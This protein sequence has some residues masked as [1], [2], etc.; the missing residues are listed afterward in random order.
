MIA[1][2]PTSKLGRFSVVGR[3][4]YVTACFILGTLSDHATDHPH[5][6]IPLAE[7]MKA[8]SRPQNL[9]DPFDIP[10][11]PVSESVSSSDEELFEHALTLQTP[12]APTKPV[13][14][15]PP[16]PPPRSKITTDS[17]TPS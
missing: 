4:W 3:T 5:G 9:T 1:I 7:I 17:Q 16:P 2:S 6:V 14:R 11:S 15:K 12:L 8:H 10:D 13:P